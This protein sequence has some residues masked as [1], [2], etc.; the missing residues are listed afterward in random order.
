M[1]HVSILR[2]PFIFLTTK[3]RTQQP[4][5]LLKG[6]ENTGT[7][8]IFCVFLKIVLNFLRIQLKEKRKI[9]FDKS[10]NAFYLFLVLEDRIERER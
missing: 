7:S 8:I 9:L 4:L 2:N 3:G 5:V 10:A 1:I 6:N